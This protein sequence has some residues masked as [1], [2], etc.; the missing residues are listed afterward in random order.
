LADKYFFSFPSSSSHLC[1]TVIWPTIRKAY[2][3]CAQPS[4]GEEEKW[5]GKRKERRKEEVMVG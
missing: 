1:D 4:K 5:E 3:R 2:R